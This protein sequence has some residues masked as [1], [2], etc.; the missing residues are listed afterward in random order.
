VQGEKGGATGVKEWRAA[1]VRQALG[2]VMVVAALDEF[3]Q[4]FV[5]S[6][7]SSPWDAL[8]DTLGAALFLAVA[9][10]VRI[11]KAPPYAKAA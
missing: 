9:W 5:P 3:H 2:I 6:R 4:S 11:R 8:L 7:G 10:L 1:W